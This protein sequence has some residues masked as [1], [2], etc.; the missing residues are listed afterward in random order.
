MVRQRLRRA[1]RT[2]RHGRLTAVGVVRSRRAAPLVL[3]AFGL[4]ACADDA[5]PTAASPTTAPPTAARPAVVDE[6][7]APFAAMV[8]AAGPRVPAALLDERR[9][10]VQAA[11]DDSPLP[12]HVSFATDDA[13][14]R[15]LLDLA[16][17]DGAAV[18]CVV[19]RDAVRVASPVAAARPDA[20]VCAVG[21]VGDTR[22]EDGDAPPSLLALV[23]R[24]DELAELLAAG[25]VEVAP[26]DGRVALVVDDAGWRTALGDEVG[27]A[28]AARA[29]ADA[30]RLRAEQADAAGAGEA[31][32]DGTGS[33][34]GALP[35]VPR[36]TTTVVADTLEGA[37][38]GSA[39]RGVPAWL[40]VVDEATEVAGLRIGTGR[41]V[42]LAGPEVVLVGPDGPP[43]GDVLL[44]WR[45]D[46]RPAVDLA[47]DASTD[48]AW[49]PGEVTLGVADGTFELVAGPSEQAADAFAATEERADALAEV[50][51]AALPAPSSDDQP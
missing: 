19:G 29:T 44:A 2:A 24:A 43:A 16:V 34:A 33:G 50:A 31:P 27:E 39:L 3:L 5:P 10:A 32:T 48:E 36:V 8:L 46:L 45:H 6:P 37:A 18:A 25:A 41:D 26:Q 12:V 13:T 40:A 1:R 22:D 28:A 21:E 30:E 38:L 20:R 7:P 23:P 11:A 47:L 14:A 49:R 15:D 9:T 35:E 17:D 4:V 51:N 42:L